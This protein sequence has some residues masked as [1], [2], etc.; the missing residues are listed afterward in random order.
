MSQQNVYKI[1][2]QQWEF[3]VLHGHT[4]KFNLANLGVMPCTHNLATGSQLMWLSLARRGQQVHVAGC[5]NIFGVSARCQRIVCRPSVVEVIK[6][7]RTSA[8]GQ[9]VS[10]SV[11]S[12]TVQDSVCGSLLLCGVRSAVVWYW[13]PVTHYTV[14]RQRLNLHIRSGPGLVCACLSVHP[15]HSGPGLIRITWLM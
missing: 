14:A 10:L 15:W 9:P 4:D 2:V 3:R 6:R 13:V 12:S 8:A 5:T 11:W 1:S 7:Q